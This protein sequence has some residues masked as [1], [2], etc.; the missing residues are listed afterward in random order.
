MDPIRNS[1][2]SLVAVATLLFLLVAFDSPPTTSS[3]SV[4]RPAPPTAEELA[5][6]A[7]LSEW[8]L[9]GS[10]APRFR[11]F[12][13]RTFSSS[14]EEKP[15]GFELFRDYHGE[16]PQA[17]LVAR[18]PFGDLIAECARRYDVDSVLLVAMIEAESSFNPN[19][20]SAVGAIGLMQVMPSTARIYS[21]GDPF[22]P[23]VNVDIGARYLRSLLDQFGDL[24]LALA[25]YNA[26][27]GNVRRFEGVPPFRETRSYVQRVMARYVDYHQKIWLESPDNDW[28]L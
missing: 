9:G 24:P 27:P 17:E 2:V 25:A 21:E 3:I 11:A 1:R 10:S 18:R 28:F 22:D 6:L 23:A 5:A 8:V 14:L 20:I 16:E 26:G 4:D 7:E 19:A 12:S 15:I 13:E